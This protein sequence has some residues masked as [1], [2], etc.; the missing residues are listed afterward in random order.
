[1]QPKNERIQHKNES[2]QQK[3]WRMQQKKTRMP[4]FLASMQQ[5]KRLCNKKKDYATRKR[6]CS[7]YATIAA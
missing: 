7:E 2:M 6:P 1:M 4:T 5:N 3:I